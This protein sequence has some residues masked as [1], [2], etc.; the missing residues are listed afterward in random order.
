MKKAKSS[1]V[2]EVA[3][4]TGGSRGLGLAIATDLQARGFELVLLAR[5]QEELESARNQLSRETSVELIAGDILSSETARQAA[6]LCRERFG[7]LDLLVNNAGIFRMGPIHEFSESDWKQIVGVNLTG[8]FLVTKA[9]LEL[10]RQSRGQ[11]VFI[12]S[13]GGRVGLKNLSGYSSAKFGMRGLADSL[14]NELHDYG[15]RVTSIYPHS[16]NTAGET[17]AADDPKRMT[18]IEPA[19]V[20]HLLGEIATAPEYMQVPEIIIYPR[21]TRI[22]KRER[23]PG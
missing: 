21:S 11:I 7:R 13:I 14:R 8:S 12:N 9:C 17:I 15:I 1:P 19:D 20:A 18:M 4:I 23:S 16:M 10:L 2:T 5:K 6:D 3:L 22:A